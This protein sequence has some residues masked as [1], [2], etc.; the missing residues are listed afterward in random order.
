MYRTQ[1]PPQQGT[2]VP[3]SGESRSSVLRLL[4][5]LKGT[6]GQKDILAA[7]L[8]VGFVYLG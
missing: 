3:R 1:E 2:S 5:E 6:K 8:F 4:G 7:R